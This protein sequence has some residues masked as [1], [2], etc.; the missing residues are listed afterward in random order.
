MP[1][2]KAPCL[3]VDSSAF[4]NEKLDFPYLSAG[5]D[6]NHE[7]VYIIQTPDT[8]LA[9][10]ARCRVSVSQ[11]ALRLRFAIG[12]KGPAIYTQKHDFP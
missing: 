3:G 8:E 1:L 4:K 6:G 2:T 9:T 5:F 7:W 10:L 12:A 11:R